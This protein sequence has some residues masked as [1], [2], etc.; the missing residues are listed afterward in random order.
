MS[1]KVTGTKNRR[2]QRR[3]LS[4]LFVVALLG[5]MPQDLLAQGRGKIAGTVTDA[6]TGEPLIG[7][8]VVIAGTTLGSATDVDGDYYI[9]NLEPGS[10]R[11]RATYVG[12]QT[13]VIQDVLVRANTT[14]N[15]DFSLEPVLVQ[16]EE[17]VVTAER[18]LV[19]LDN[20]TSVVRLTAA[21]VATRPTTDFANVLA[22]LPSINSENGQLVVRG[23]TLDEVAF[24][25][26]GAR[27]RNTMNNQP[28]TR[29]NLSSIA[30]LEVIT[31]S[32]NAEFGEAQSGVI[33][34]VTK[35]GGEKYELYVDSRIQPA[36]KRHWGAAFYDRSTDLYWEN[37]NARH[38]DWWIEYPDMWVDPNGN[39]GSSPNSVW[40]PEQ[41]YQNYLDTHQ[42]KND[43][44]ED[45]SYQ[46]E[47]GL[48]GP[49]PAL[50]NLF[51]FGSAKYRSEPP[52]LG[53]ASRSKG[54]F[55]D[56]T[57][58]L[59]YRFAGGK[60][61]TLSGFYGKKE[62]GWGFAGDEDFSVF[63]YP[64]WA[65]TY[66]ASGRYAFYDIVGYPFS[67]TNGQ[68][69]RFSN[70]V[71]NATLYEL[72]MS[73]VQA[74]RRQGL[75]P[76]DSLGW[77][78]ADATRDNLRAVD[79]SGT[80]ISGGHSN[81]I[82]FHTTGYFWR[83]DDSNV[84]WQFDGYVSSQVTK[85]FHVKA[86][87]DFVY[88]VLDHFNNSKL[89]DRTDE[90]TYKPYQGA[91]YAQG[92][93]E[94]RGLIVNAGLRFDLYNPNDTVYVDLFD[95]LNGEKRT[96]K[97]YTQLSPRLGIS[98]PIDN[99]TVLHFSY[100]HFFQRPNY[101]DYGEGNSFVQGSLNTFIIDGSQVPWNLGNRNL[102]P[103]K[104]IS[105]EV[106]IERNFWDFFVLDVTGYY[107]DIRN[108][109]RTISIETP[110]GVYK[111][112]GNGDYADQRGLEVSLRKVPS[113]YKWGSIWGYA[114]FSTR[115]GI[116]GRSGDPVVISPDGV[117]F[118][119]SGDFILHNNPRFK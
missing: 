5:S 110:N 69:L 67:Q 105:Y 48:G 40:T 62:A 59:S 93:V 28:Y 51:F 76:G 2:I 116:L 103:R 72:K 58:K 68:T 41:A 14:A 109:V 49:I 74:I 79:D 1:E 113:S 89:P 94:T 6:E 36:G 32:Y 44:L 118:A 45:P 52:L 88:S 43:Y 15:I 91:L 61:L 7:V 84:D 4:A 112:N 47:V 104:T 35:E 108:T 30:E 107:K 86:G 82:G 73:R 27:A 26:D 101:N 78:A 75:I 18:P 80:P 66:G 53:N 21:E 54:E 22:T 57:L 102:R 70:V 85:Q 25:V 20:T 8:N 90:R 3:I 96:T 9:A 12:Y 23:G 46:V 56:G 81:P 55:L 83:Y 114:N 111:T 13:L 63:S 11:L 64:F 10:Y 77:D 92:K 95:P 98:H 16:G 38:L 42:P 50:K 29:F 117:R 37:S 34:V 60:K 115:I 119:T 87:G 39:P 71:S 33:S 97:L 31:G 65:T 100:G 24:M 106:G 19:E 99:R 17:V